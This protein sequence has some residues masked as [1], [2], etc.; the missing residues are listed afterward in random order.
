MSHVGIEVGIWLMQSI[1]GM[2]QNDTVLYCTW[3]ICMNLYTN[4]FK[5]CLIPNTYGLRSMLVID[6]LLGDSG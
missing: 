6:S 4:I 3:P 5:V 2:V 1:S